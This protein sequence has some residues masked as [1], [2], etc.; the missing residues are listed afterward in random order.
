MPSFKRLAVIAPLI[1][2]LA[3]AA[4]ACGS[5]DKPTPTPTRA[6]AAT[7]TTNSGVVVITGDTPTP[8]PTN[9]GKLETVAAYTSTVQGLIA[10]PVT[11]LSRFYTLDP[12]VFSGIN[13]KVTPDQMELIGATV[14]I[15][16]EFH[17]SAPEVIASLRSI[18]PPSQCASVHTALVDYLDTVDKLMNGWA[19]DLEPLALGYTDAPTQVQIN[20]LTSGLQT[21]MNEA[22]EL[23]SIALA[24]PECD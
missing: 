12:D 7:A 24:S 20:R 2:G 13:G 22:D 6:P 4:I 1:G 14:N 21:V 18:I 8:L 5:G 23:A 3:I 9:I 15:A 16:S 17:K 10:A 11:T 19:I